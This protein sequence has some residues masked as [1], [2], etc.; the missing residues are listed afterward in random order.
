MVLFVWVKWTGNAL[1]ILSKGYVNYLF[2]SLG[3]R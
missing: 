1:Y 2:R 3:H